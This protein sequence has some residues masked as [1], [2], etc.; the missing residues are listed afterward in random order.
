MVASGYETENGSYA[1][2]IG[3]LVVPETE[4]IRSRA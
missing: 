1:A 3:T 4:T 2:V